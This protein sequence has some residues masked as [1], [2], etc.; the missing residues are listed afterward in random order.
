MLKE[1]IKHISFDKVIM[2]KEL[3]EAVEKGEVVVGV[4]EE[5]ER[6][7]VGKKLKGYVVE[8]ERKGGG[9][10]VVGRYSQ[11][12]FKEKKEKIKQIDA[13]LREGVYVSDY[14][15]ERGFLNN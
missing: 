2:V 13:I 9:D 7:E 6:G 11:D 12:E 1:E 10:G 3:I 5:R 4:L 8:S 15:Q 14:I